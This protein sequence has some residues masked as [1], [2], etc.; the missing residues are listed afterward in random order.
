VLLYHHTNK[1]SQLL[2]INFHFHFLFKIAIIKQLQSVK[3]TKSNGIS[4]N[5]QQQQPQHYQWISEYCL[6][7]EYK[8]SMIRLSDKGR[9][10]K[11]HAGRNQQEKFE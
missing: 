6:A 9:I 2:F 8:R 7:P 1:P 3:R 4:I 10:Q 11:N 5:F